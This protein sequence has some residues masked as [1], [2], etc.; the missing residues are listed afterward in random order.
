M[1]QPRAD[2]TQRGL[3]V[4]LPLMPENVLTLREKHGIYMAS[5]GRIDI[6]GL[7]AG[8]V[9]RFAEAVRPLLVAGR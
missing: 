7:M 3:F 6:A 4:L 5:N 1:A 9:A 8:N 2:L